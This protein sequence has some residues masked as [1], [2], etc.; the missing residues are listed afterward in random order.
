MRDLERKEQ[1][2][3]SCRLLRSFGVFDEQGHLSVRDEEDPDTIWVNAFTSP[4]TVNLQDV[5]PVDLTA[6]EYPEKAPAEVVI[7]TAI[8]R[9]RDDVKSVCHNHSPFAVAVAGAGLDMRPVH[10]CGAVQTTPITVFEDYHDEGGVLVMDEAEGDDIAEA[11][12]DDRAVI[13]RG[14]GP[15]VAAEGLIETVLACI[16]LEY[17]SRLLHR[18]AQVGEPWYLPQDL[19]ETSESFM[20]SDAVM[21]KSLDYYLTHME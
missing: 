7:H 3:R 5:I 1:L 17:N 9:A 10:H 18:Q 16:K 15:V 21:E 6:A 2:V 13:L 11:L 8:Y 12:G 14:H 19:L 20:F 4:S